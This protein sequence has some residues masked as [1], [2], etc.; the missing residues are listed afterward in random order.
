MH[1]QKNKHKALVDSTSMPRQK[2]PHRTDDERR[3]N[4]HNTKPMNMLWNGRRRIG[5]AVS[6]RTR[7]TSHI[8]R[9]TS[10]QPDN[11]NH[12]NDNNPHENNTELSKFFFSRACCVAEISGFVLCATV[13]RLASWRVTPIRRRDRCALF[14]RPATVRRHVTYTHFVCAVAHVRKHAA[15]MMLMNIKKI[16]DTAV[17]A[18]LPHIPHTG[19][20]QSYARKLC[21]VTWLKP[22]VAGIWWSLC[23]SLFYIFVVIVGHRRRRRKRIV[24]SG[25]ICWHV[26]AST[27]LNGR[28]LFSY[29]RDAVDNNWHNFRPEVRHV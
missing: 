26:L 5:F 24:L 15:T 9:C 27:I 10:H 4:Y 7:R 2:Q 13:L 16:Q 8:A 29:R 3:S 22:S 21:R 11:N 17:A 1:T 28:Y 12:N 14:F 6:A 25:R 18:G 23:V 19:G 20:I